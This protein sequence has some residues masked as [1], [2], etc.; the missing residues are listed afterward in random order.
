MQGEA[1]RE[2]FARR[3]VHA[4]KVGEPVV[5]LD[6]GVSRLNGDYW[7]DYAKAAK[8]RAH[9][10][11]LANPY[12]QQGGRG[13]L[14]QYTSD[15]TWLLEED[16]SRCFYTCEHPRPTPPH[17]GWD[18][19]TAGKKPAPIIRE[20]KLPSHTLLTHTGQAGR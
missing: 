13:T 4:P 6:C 17:H 11:H 18:I 10:S 2:P 1:P 12:R 15:G 16:Y 5:V 9:L 3:Q 19:G 20:P 7:P 14:I 8:L